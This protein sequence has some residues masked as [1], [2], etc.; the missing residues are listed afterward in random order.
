E[1]VIDGY[2]AGTIGRSTEAGTVRQT[3]P[4][5]SGEGAAA[6]V[7]F[8]QARKFDAENGRLNGIEPGYHAEFGA[9][10]AARL[11]MI[12]QQPGPLVNLFVIGDEHSTIAAGIE[13]LER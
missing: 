3:P 8:R 13:V 2:L 5:L 7:D 11:A 10:I 12:A 6:G 4:V 1:G 9:I